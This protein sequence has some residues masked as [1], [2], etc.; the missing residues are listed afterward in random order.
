MGVLCG[1]LTSNGTRVA[2]LVFEMR[3]ATIP[4]VNLRQIGSA[5]ALAFLIGCSS[6]TLPD[7]G[8]GGGGADTGGTPTDALIVGGC[9]LGKP[10]RSKPCFTCA[11]RRADSHEVGCGG[12]LPMLWGWDGSGIASGVVYPL[13]CTVYL[14]VENPYYPGEPQSCTCVQIGG[15]ELPQWICPI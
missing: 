14:P 7:P 3:R 12:P 4:T 9:Q 15:S 11:P 2:I 13:L 1:S 6:Q 10:L 5:C 8:D